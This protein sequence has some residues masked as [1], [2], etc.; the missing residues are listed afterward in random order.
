[1]SLLS[2]AKGTFSVALESTREGE[3]AQKIEKTMND[4]AAVDMDFRLAVSEVFLKQRAELLT[5]KT[6]WST[7]MQARVGRGLQ[8]S[9]EKMSRQAS[10][11]NDEVTSYGLWLAG[12]WLEAGALKSESAQIAHFVLE[13]MT[14]GQLNIGPPGAFF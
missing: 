1:M 6:T 12:A 2:L 5:Q 14:K 10:N 8:V 11:S 9:S 3:L 13:N 4:L 7:D